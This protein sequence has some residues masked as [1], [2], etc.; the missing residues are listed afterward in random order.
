[1]VNKLEHLSVCLLAVC[2]SS[3]RKCL[4]RSS[5]HLLI[6]L[7]GFG[8]GGRVGVELYELFICFGYYPLSVIS[9]ADIFSYSLGYLF[10]LLMVCFAMQKLLSLIRFHLLLLLF[11]LT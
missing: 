5:E 6:G 1:M 4:F 3:L 2:V 9:F 8:E 7:F 11:P 10:V